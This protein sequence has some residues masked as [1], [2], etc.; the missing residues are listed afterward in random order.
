MFL[1]LKVMAEQNSLNITTLSSLARAV[2]AFRAM[3]D[4]LNPVIKPLMDSIKTEENEQMQTCSANT[5]A[6][7]LDL[8]HKRDPC[9]NNK[10]LKNICIFLCADAEF[11]PKIVA[12]ELQG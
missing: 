8:C 4:K 3:P 5:L 7:L 11:T 1:I 9:P 10:I 12:D 6:R 2:V